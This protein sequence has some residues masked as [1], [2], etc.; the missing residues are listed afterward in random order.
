[1]NENIR[2]TELN[3][4][5]ELAEEVSSNVESIKKRYTSL[6]FYFVLITSFFAIVISLYIYIYTSKNAEFVKFQYTLLIALFLGLFIYMIMLIRLLN[7]RRRLLFKM[8][9][10]YMILSDLLEMIHSYKEVVFEDLSIVKK[11]LLDM[12]LNRISYRGFRGY[13]NPLNEIMGRRQV[14]HG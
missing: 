4:L 8:K 10:E 9:N 12:R 1:M 5:I 14:D 11:A 13:E 2:L 3:D 7:E 6:F